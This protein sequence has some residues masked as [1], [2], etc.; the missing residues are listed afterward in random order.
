M[1]DV[2]TPP[3]V[4]MPRERGATSRRSRSDTASEV[5]PVRMAACTKGYYEICCKQC[6]GAL[7]PDSLRSVDPDPYSEYG[8]G[9][10]RAKGP[11]KV[12]KLRNFMF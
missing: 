12:K 3:A 10:R 11:T 5:S 9:S 6:S 1:S 7:D 2:I 4:S 8:S